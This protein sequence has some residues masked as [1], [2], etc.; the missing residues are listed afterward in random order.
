MKRS[1]T[2]EP[3]NNS[4]KAFIFIF[5]IFIWQLIYWIVRRDIYVPSPFMVVEA[6]YELVQTD[7]F[8]MSIISSILRVVS[9]LMISVVFGV[10]LG[11]LSGMRPFVFH[12][13]NPMMTAIKST[14]VMSFIIIALVWFKSDYVP[15][16]ICFLMCFPIIWTNV[17]V[18]I[19]QVDQKLLEMAHVYKVKERYIVKDIYI[20]SIM[21]YFTAALTMALGLGWKVSVAAE[22][23][24]HP[25]FA[26]GS[27]LHSAKAYLDTP[28]LFAWTIAVILLSLLFEKI[29]KWGML[30][31]GTR[32]HRV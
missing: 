26:I 14:P 1:T 27:N 13:L 29:L 17:V 32:G 31:G 5:W 11:V 10:G 19:H 12:L 7:M 21:P 4:T 3:L 28:S 23:L 20:P 24:S 16:F 25:H 15:I 30:K 6:F 2:K 18:G 22:V 8:W 9:G